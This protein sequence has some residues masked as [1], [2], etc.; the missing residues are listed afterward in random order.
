MGQVVHP[1][2]PLSYLVMRIWSKQRKVWRCKRDLLKFQ[3]KIVCGC[4]MEGCVW[5]GVMNEFERWASIPPSYPTVIPSDGDME[6]AVKG[7]EVKKRSSKSS[8]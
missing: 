6:L 4:G 3:S 2:L 5:R 8:K 1:A 7:T